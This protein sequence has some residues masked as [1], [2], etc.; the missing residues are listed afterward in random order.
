MRDVGGKTSE[1]LSSSDRDRVLQVGPSRLQHVRELGAL[2]AKSIGE[3]A[4]ALQEARQHQEE[5][6]TRRG[7]IHVVR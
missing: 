4:R 5:R 1:L 2:L 6:E 7:G 3:G